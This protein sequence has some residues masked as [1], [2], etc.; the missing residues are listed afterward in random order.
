M[1]GSVELAAHAGSRRGAGR[2]LA[3]RSIGRRASRLAVAMSA[4]CSR[5][6]RARAR[7]L[8]ATLVSGGSLGGTSMR[9]AC[10]PSGAL[11]KCSQN[12]LYER[13]KPRSSAGS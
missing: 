3:V 4:Q 5:R 10:G 2:A 8:P 12:S 13:R 7:C 9:W 11:P 1:P 6:A